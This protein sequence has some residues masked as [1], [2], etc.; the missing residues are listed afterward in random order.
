MSTQSILRGVGRGVFVVVILGVFTMVAIQ[1][2]RIVH[3]NVVLAHALWVVQTDITRLASEK[4]RRTATI[5]RLS[6]PQGAIP[7]IHDRLH[8]TM[9]NESIIYLKG[10]KPQ[11]APQ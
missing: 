10:N 2:A 9:P 1:Y 11:T 4:D 5:S 7:E 3:R 8:L 6:D